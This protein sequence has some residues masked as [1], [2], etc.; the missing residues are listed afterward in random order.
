MDEINPKVH[1][2]YPISINLLFLALPYL[3]LNIQSSSSGQNNIVTSTV[4]TNPSIC[5]NY[6]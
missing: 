6:N 4:P 3:L 5:Q 1:E 2:K